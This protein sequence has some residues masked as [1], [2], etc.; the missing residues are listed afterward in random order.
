MKFCSNTSEI[1]SYQI[2]KLEDFN[3]KESALF[4]QL[5]TNEFYKS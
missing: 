2:Q 3:L 1:D 5:C 4:S